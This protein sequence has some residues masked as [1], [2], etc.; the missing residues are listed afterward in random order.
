MFSEC[1]LY[2]KI[3]NA[4]FKT[5]SRMLKF[6]ASSI[7]Q[8]IHYVGTQGL[9]TMFEFPRDLHSLLDVVEILSKN[10]R[11]FF[12]AL[13]ETTASAL[14]LTSSLANGCYSKER[15]MLN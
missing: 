3:R 1:I 15:L 5:Q 11:G 13:F 6:Y 7:D 12:F 4:R 8:C 2:K 9:R 10:I 14:A